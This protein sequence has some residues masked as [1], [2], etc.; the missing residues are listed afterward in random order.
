MLRRIPTQRAKA[1]PEERDRAEERAPREDEERQSQRRHLAH[2][3][4]GDH[5]DDGGKARQCTR[6]LSL[7]FVFLLRPSRRPV[8]LGIDC[9]LGVPLFASFAGSLRTLL[10][11]CA[12][13]LS[14]RG[15]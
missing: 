1:R 3:D 13:G 12:F 9:S 5:H 14:H 11:L 15:P 6:H 8:R 2:H 10:L 7:R 4:G